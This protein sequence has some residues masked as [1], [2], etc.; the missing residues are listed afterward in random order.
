MLGVSGGCE[1]EFALKFNRRTENLKD[2]YTVYCKS[3]KEYC[4]VKGIELTD[5]IELPSYFIT[6]SEIKWCNRI[7]VQSAMQEYVDTAISST[8][9]LDENIPI[10]EV[11]QIYLSSWSHGLKGITLFRNNCKRLAILSTDSKKEE[12]NK[13]N[14]EN[15]NDGM[16][17]KVNKSDCINSYDD[18]PWG[19][20]INVDNDLKGI[21]RKIVNGCGAFH[22]QAFYDELDGRIWETFISLGDGAGCE[23][24]LEFI[25]RLISKCLRAG[26]TIDE[27]VESAQSVRPCM[28]YC[29]RKKSKGDTSNGTS[30]P[31]AIGCALKD[32]ANKIKEEYCIAELDDFVEDF[33][34]SIVEEKSSVVNVNEKITHDISDTP[35]Q[36]DKLI[37]P[38]CGEPLSFEGG[39]NI[40]HN[41]GWSKCS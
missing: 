15:I 14:K 18:L 13:E 38:D 27:I 26:V 9:N 10:D 36:N 2:N 16:N 23:R 37:C 3:V 25:S 19:T 24:N 21:K 8:I 33:D 5:D 1:P 35:I 4:D 17:P 34:K 20:I 32:F 12:E 11:E 7:N 6:S 41:C 22:L 30:C 40:C 31:S 39:C 28:A 29:N